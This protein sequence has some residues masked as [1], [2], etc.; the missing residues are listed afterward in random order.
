VRGIRLLSSNSEL[1]KRL[2]EN[3]REE[4]VKKYTWAKHIE[5]IMEKLDLMIKYHSA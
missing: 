3:A 4:I 2:G 1:R 5:R